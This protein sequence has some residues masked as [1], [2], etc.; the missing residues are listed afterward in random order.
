MEHDRLGCEALWKVSSDS[1]SSSGVSMA[2]KELFSSKAPLPGCDENA[3]LRNRLVF[4]SSRCGTRWRA[5]AETAMGQWV[6]IMQGTKRN[7]QHNHKMCRANA[8]DLHH[9]RHTPLFASQ[10]RAFRREAPEQLTCLTKAP[11]VLPLPAPRSRTP[12]LQDSRSPPY[13]PA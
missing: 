8:E 3:S 11:C 13:L 4:K 2:R 12:G 7:S 5:Y 6:P 1:G 10:R 9:P